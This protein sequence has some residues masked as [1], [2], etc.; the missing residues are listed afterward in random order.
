MKNKSCYI[1]DE[2][3]HPMGFE[4]ELHKKKKSEERQAWKN[5]KIASRIRMAEMMAA[6]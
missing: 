3:E 2:K 6:K 1:M 4:N 5:G